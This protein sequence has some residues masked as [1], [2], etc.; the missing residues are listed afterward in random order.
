MLPLFQLARVSCD[1]LEW[2]KVHRHR[3]VTV[4]E[5]M[6]KYFKHYFQQIPHLVIGVSLWRQQRPGWPGLCG[7]I[8]KCDRCLQVQ[9]ARF[10][11]VLALVFDV[12]Q[13][14]GL[15]LFNHFATHGDVHGH[16]VAAGV[17]EHIALRCLGQPAADDRGGVQLDACRC[18]G[19]ACRLQAKCLVT[20]IACLFGA[21]VACKTAPLNGAG[22]GATE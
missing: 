13:Q 19:R 6:S 14:V 3:S 11:H 12:G 16:V 20:L 7:F 22:G 17:F 4:F 21:E 2:S 10:A 15:L 1:G 8:S 5:P 9:G 18:S